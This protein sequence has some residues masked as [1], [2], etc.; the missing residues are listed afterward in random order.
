MRYNR[1]HK[2][3]S[4]SRQIRYN[5]NLD[6]IEVPDA[7]SY[8]PISNFISALNGQTFSYF[9]IIQQ[10]VLRKKEENIYNYCN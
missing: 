1:F 7:Q 5:S 10:Q 9:E 3:N 4:L 8:Q 6:L 2:E